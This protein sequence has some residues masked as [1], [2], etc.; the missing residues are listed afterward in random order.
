LSTRR[1]AA[2]GVKAGFVND[3][4]LAIGLEVDTGG[5]ARCAIVAG[6]LRC[7][8]Q[9]MTLICAGGI[10][11]L[12]SLLMFNAVAEAR[13]TLGQKS[14]DNNLL[15]KL[16][17]LRSYRSCNPPKIKSQ[18]SSHFRHN[19]PQKPKPYLANSKTGGASTHT[20][21]DLLTHLWLLSTLL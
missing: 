2:L 7:E 6:Q 1:A 13:A 8:P 4:I 11:G 3:A 5:L 21:T 15:Q 16:V 18:N 17:G 14:K 12:G 19:R 20:P 9:I 10:G